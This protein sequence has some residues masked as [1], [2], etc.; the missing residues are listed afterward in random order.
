MI[1]HIVIDQKFIDMAYDIFEAVYPGKNE[2]ILPTK[3]LKKQLE[4]IKKTPV[5]KISYL[6]FL[7]KSFYKDL[8]KYD[9]VVLHFLNNINKYMIKKS[10]DNIKFVWIGWG[11]D[12]YD[13]I[14]KEIL[15]PKTKELKISKTNNTKKINLKTI[16]Q[17]YIS[18][19][20]NRSINKINYFAPVLYED[21]ILFKNNTNFNIEYIDWNYGTLEDHLIQDSDLKLTDNNILLGNSSSYE[22]NHLEAFDILKN[23]DL[24]DKKI[25][26][27][28][29]Y[30]DKEYAN[31]V[32]N[33]GKNIFGDKLNP[34]INFMDIKDY[35]KNISSCSN[36]IMNHKRQQALGNIIIMLYM[37]S[38]IFLDK[39]NP[40]YEFLNKNGI[41]LFGIEDINE[42][43]LEQKL[44]EEKVLKNREILNNLWGRDVIYKKT[45]KLIETL[46]N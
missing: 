11:S 42:S 18:E 1:L 33:Y 16:I 36:V 10:P 21:Y 9:F 23:I 15:L 12:Y 19:Y 29:S 45:K 39:E 41:I 20:L 34:L 28:L 3:N 14:N 8:K 17:K 32:I 37:G 5:K 38:K 30:G 7:S 2:Y 35:I 26:V 31:E 22:N 27:P 43:N 4:Y 46:L 25:I 40:A 13:F 44:E 6:Q 24:K